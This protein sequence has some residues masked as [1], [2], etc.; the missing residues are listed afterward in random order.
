MTWQ[1]HIEV[2]EAVLAGKPVVKGSRL[3]VEYLIELM[4]RGWTEEQILENYPG[5]TSADLRA[6]LAYAHE[7]L[8]GEK[9]FPLTAG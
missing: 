3:A 2:N 5:L 7:V 1:D 6:C 9:V 4:A 8:S